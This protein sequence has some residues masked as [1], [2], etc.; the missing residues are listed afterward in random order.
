[1]KLFL[2]LIVAVSFFSLVVFLKIVLFCFW[3]LCF[4]P[5]F[6]QESLRKII[7]IVSNYIQQHC[8]TSVSYRTGNILSFLSSALVQ[9]LSP[10]LIVNVNSI[11]HNIPNGQCFVAQ[12]RKDGPKHRTVYTTFHPLKT[13][14]ISLIIIRERRHDSNPILND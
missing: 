1:M 10:R 2:S 8:Y 4:V 7:T 5:A 12:K 11:T 6:I 3:T 9:I 14:F 13:D